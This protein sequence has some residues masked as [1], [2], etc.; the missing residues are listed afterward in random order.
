MSFYNLHQNT[1]NIKDI[2]PQGELSI[3]KLEIKNYVHF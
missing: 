1:F 2:S 3:K